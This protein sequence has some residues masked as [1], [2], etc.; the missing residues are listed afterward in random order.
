VSGEDQAAEPAAT[1]GTQTPTKTEAETEP[2][3]PVALDPADDFV[4]VD[5]ESA[6]EPVAPRARPRIP[7]R[8]R[9]RGARGTAGAEVT[10]PAGD[11][12]PALEIREPTAIVAGQNLFKQYG[13]GP[14]AVRALNGVSIDL[15]PGTFTAIMGPS[16]SGKSTLMHLLAGLDTPTRGEVWIGPTRLGELGEAD[17][18]RLRRSRVGFVFQSFNLLPMLTVE[19]NITLPQRI[20][21]RRIDTAW[22]EWLLNAIGLPDRRTSRPAELS[23]GEQ[24]RVSLAR[25]LLGKPTVVFADEPTGNLDSRSTE[26]IL[27]MLRRAVADLGQTIVIVTHD[28]QAAARADRIVFLED[29]KIIRET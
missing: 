27:T 19:Q 16:G 8:L 29:G 25:A 11:G 14:A 26:V 10:A 21:G 1:Q 22:L 5:P 17:R 13:Q 24:Q 18:T 4:T 20:A 15:Y 12:L 9:R 6:A 3:T 7:G 2:R 23:G 28:P